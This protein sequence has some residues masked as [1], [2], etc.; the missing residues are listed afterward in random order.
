MMLPVAELDS[1]VKELDTTLIR[2]KTDY[3]NFTG[4][5]TITLFC[6]TNDHKLVRVY[7]SSWTEKINDFM[8]NRNLI[9]SNGDLRKDIMNLKVPIKVSGSFDGYK[10]K[11]S[12]VS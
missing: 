5:Q 8:L 6:E 7:F 9:N 1:K 11:R 4:G 12:K 10:V 2:V 3:N